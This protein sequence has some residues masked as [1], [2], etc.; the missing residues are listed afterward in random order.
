MEIEIIENN[1]EEI[2]LNKSEI[3][4]YLALL[5][6]DA[7]STGPIIKESK[8]ADSK[9]YEVLEKLTQKGLVS[10]FTKGKVK[11]YKAASPKMILEFLKEKRENIQ[12]QE[13]KVN[14]LLPQLLQFQ[15]QEETDNEATIFTGN[16]GIK[17]AFTNIV[18]ELDSGEE[19]HIMGVHNF[20]EKFMHLAQYFQNARSHKKIKAKFLMDASAKE[21]AKE[22]KK[23]PP[24]QIRFMPEEILTPA[25][26]LIYKDKVVINLAKEMTFF[27]IKSQSAKD[28]FDAYF[29]LM[30]KQ[31]KK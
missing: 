28:T 10:H 5:K 8:T 7:S 17:T 27:V 9:I 12:K 30:W 1:L 21:I 19:I 18:D 26:F 16:K 15:K 25:I 3:K 14:Q 22:F 6:L 23:Y 29:Q 11:R 2:G 20:G 31:S 4:V 24:T 13:T